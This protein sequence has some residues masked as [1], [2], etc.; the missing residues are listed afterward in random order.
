[1]NHP[2]KSYGSG[3]TNL[4]EVRRRKPF[5]RNLGSLV[6]GCIEQRD[7]EIERP[8]HQRNCFGLG[9]ISPPALGNRPVSKPDFTNGQV[10]VL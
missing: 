2:S 3:G 6:V 7:T 4:H 9:K 8:V 5:T 10:S 1:M